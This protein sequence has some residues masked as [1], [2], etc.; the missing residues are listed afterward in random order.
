MNCVDDYSSRLICM[1]VS[2]VCMYVCKVFLSCRCHFS[3]RLLK[4]WLLIVYVVLPLHID[5]MKRK[6]FQLMKNYLLTGL[7]QRMILFYWLLLVLRYAFGN[8]PI[9]VTFVIFFCLYYGIISHS[10]AF[11]FKGKTVWPYSL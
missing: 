1:F 11:Q 10:F 5:H 4:T 8:L 9:I 7:Y 2:C 3:K 6:R